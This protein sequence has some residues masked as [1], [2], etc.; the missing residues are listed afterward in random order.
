MKNYIKSVISL[1]IICA[2]VASLLAVTNAI[3]APIIEEK[4]S[5]AADEA[6]LVVL[7]DGEG[8]TQLDISGYT[9]PA[10]VTDVYTTTNGGCVVKLLTVGYGADMVIMCG[11]NANGEITGATCLSSEV[12]SGKESRKFFFINSP[13][14]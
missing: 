2:I 6:L 12:R 4:A 7:P 10:T 8:F 1:T 14:R 13:A 5:A 3:T 9:L 11:I